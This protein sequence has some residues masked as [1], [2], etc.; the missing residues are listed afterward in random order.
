MAATEGRAVAML[1]SKEIYYA[2]WG[3]VH[4]LHVMLVRLLWQAYRE[5]RALVTDL[6]EHA[7]MLGRAQPVGVATQLAEAVRGFG[8]TMQRFG[9]TKDGRSIL[10]CN[11]LGRPCGE[12]LHKIREEIRQGMYDALIL[13]RP[14]LQGIQQ[15]SRKQVQHYAVVATPRRAAVIRAL[16]GGK[17]FFPGKNQEEECPYCRE[18]AH[19]AVHMLWHCRGWQEHRREPFRPEWPP[20]FVNAAIPTEDLR[21]AVGAPMVV[22]LTDQMADIL[23][24]QSEEHKARQR[25]AAAEP[26]DLPE[27][28]LPPARRRLI[29]KQPAPE[30][31]P[32][33]GDQHD[34]RQQL[35]EEDA[36]GHRL[37]PDG[38]RHRCGKVTK[39]SRK[40]RLLAQP[41]TGICQQGRQTLTEA[42]AREE[43]AFELVCRQPEAAWRCLHCRTL[44]AAGHRATMGNMRRHY[45]K[46][47]RDLISHLRQRRAEG[48]ELLKHGANTHQVVRDHMSV[49][50]APLWG[51][52]QCG[53]TAHFWTSTSEHARRFLAAPCKAA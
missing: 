9:L 27:P 44:V 47:P 24:A 7:A 23:L 51:C 17:Y 3:P 33:Q 45:H 5:D 29:G 46:C 18:P 14:S 20:C 8:W 36:N 21:R 35:R 41:C 1:P 12:V 15:A 34:Q 4:R 39:W 42:W 52:I 25:R 26:A 49:E 43:L 10:Q 40:R 13:R 38:D 50:G 48:A 16:Q 30:E 32:A 28:P 11:E 37:R 2:L 6:W 22:K 19:Y 31:D 53:A